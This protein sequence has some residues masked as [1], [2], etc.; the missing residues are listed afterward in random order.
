MQTL[1]IAKERVATNL[2]HKLVVFDQM[3]KEATEEDNEDKIKKYYL[4][5]DNLLQRLEKV[6]VK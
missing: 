1:E 3:V 5:Q 2:L 4:Q 6:V